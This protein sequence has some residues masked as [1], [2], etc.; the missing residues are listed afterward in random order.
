MPDPPS[1][2]PRDPDEQAVPQKWWGGCCGC[3]IFLV[4]A[5]ATV[6]LAAIVVKAVVRFLST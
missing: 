1:P 5:A 2:V 3:L 6:T 4:S